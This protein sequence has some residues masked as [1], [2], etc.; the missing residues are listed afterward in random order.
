M[1]AE[2]ISTGTE[3]LLGNIVDTNTAYLAEQLAMLGIDLYFASTVGD[4][5]DR[6]L[7]AL[8]TAWERSDVILMTGGLGPT[9]GDITRDVIAG[10][11]GETQEVD[12]GLKMTLEKFFTTRGIAMSANNLKQAMLIPSAQAIP[13]ARGTAPGWW[14]E[15]DGKIIIAMPGPPAEMQTMWQ[16]HIAPALQNRSGGVI[17]SRTLKTFGMPEGSVDEQLTPLLKSANPTLAIYAKADGIHLRITAKADSQEVARQLTANYEQS[18]RGIV[19]KYIWGVDDDDLGAMVAKM[20]I[21]KGLTLAVVET[22]TSGALIQLLAHTPESDRFFKGGYYAASDEVKTSLGLVW[23][24]GDMAKTA[25]AIASLVRDK[26]HAGIGIDIEGYMEKSDDAPTA[27][28]FIAI[29]GVKTSLSLVRSFP[30]RLTNLEHRI[31][32]QVLFELKKFLSEN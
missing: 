27:K 9:Q 15:K 23:G 12:P 8:K 4:N 6:L 2:I 10:L 13:N 20:L 32:Y 3:L 21:A 1:K 30:G 31:A 5:F 22:F 14:A 25:A 16:K 17:L 28:V 24:A 19:D 18:V 7:G 29:A 26:V 11:L